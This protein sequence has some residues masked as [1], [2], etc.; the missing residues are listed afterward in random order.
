MTLYS[1]NYFNKHFKN[2]YQNQA[3]NPTYRKKVKEIMALGYKQGKVLDIGCAYGYLLK[4]FEQ[5][6]FETYGIDISNFALK[7]A[8]KICQAKLLKVDVSLEKIPLKSNSI[9]IVLQMFLLEHLQNYYHCLKE[10]HRVLKK[11]GLLFI[12]LPTIKRWFGD[13]THLNIFTPESLKVVL[14]K[15]GFKI[16]KLGE[17]GGPFMNPLGVLKLIFKGNTYFNFVPGKSGEFI[18]CYA[19]KN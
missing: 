12:Y 14:K 5:M 8:E 18:C 7:K 15:M 16:V 11:S 19:K 3:S 1:K 17:E 6:A 4:E 9:D 10:T 2:G 13:K